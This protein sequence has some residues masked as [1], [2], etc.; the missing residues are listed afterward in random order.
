MTPL[1]ASCVAWENGAV[2]LRGP[3][4]AGKSDLSWRAIIQAGAALVAD[5]RV[6]LDRQGTRIMAKA[7]LPGLIELRGVGVIETDF[8]ATAEL[9][10]IVDLVGDMPRMP[11]QRYE[12]LLGISLPRV[13]LEAFHALAPYRLKIALETIGQH[14]FAAEGVYPWR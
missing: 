7:V 5:D 13:E 8:L 4:G 2:L 12:D 14:G 10:L 6:N 9:K 3:S 1:A 11:E